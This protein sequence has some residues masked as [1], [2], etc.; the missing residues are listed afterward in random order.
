MTI[1]SEKDPSQSVLE[2]HGK[3]IYLTALKKL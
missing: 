1:T 3:N 2:P